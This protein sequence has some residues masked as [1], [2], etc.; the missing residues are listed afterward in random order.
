MQ[1]DAGLDTGS[2]LLQE[3]LPI[4]SE[5]T[6]KTLHD[7]LAALG[8]RLI[9]C[10]LEEPRTPQPQTEALATYALLGYQPA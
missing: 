5:D 3:A 8:G 2:I 6:A 9:V 4:A 10:A 1:M 7:R